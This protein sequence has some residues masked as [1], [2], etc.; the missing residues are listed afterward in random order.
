MSSTDWDVLLNDGSKTK[1]FKK[2]EICLREGESQ[3]DLYQITHGS[4]RIEKGG[5]V[6]A[7]LGNGSIFGEL[8]FLEWYSDGTEAKASANVVADERKVEMV[9]LDGKLVWASLAK[10][11]RLRSCF[12]VYMSQLIVARL[13]KTLELTYGQTESS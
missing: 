3:N 4:V 5:N 8:S 2:D 12:F 11:A 7:K 1:K 9:M 13:R 6:V 10:N